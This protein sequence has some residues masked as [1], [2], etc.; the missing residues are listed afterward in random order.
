MNEKQSSSFSNGVEQTIVGVTGL[1][2]TFHDNSVALIHE[3]KLLFAASQ[4]RYSRIKHDRSFPLQALSAA[5]RYSKLRFDDVTT[6]A[7]GYPHRRM[8]SVITHRY[9]YDFP[10]LV[11]NLLIYRHI[12]LLKDFFLIVREQRKQQ[13]ESATKQID[14]NK[15]HV[16]YVDHHKAHAASAYYTSGYQECIVI[17]LDGFGSMLSGTLR[18][19]AAFIADKHTLKEVMSVPI[20]ASL[21]LFYQSVT[22]AL[23]F[24][25]G[26]GEGKTMGLA[27]YG[28]ASHT[29]HKLRPFAPHFHN[30]SWQKGRHWLSAFFSTQKQ[31]APLFYSTPLGR[32]LKQLA[33]QEKPEDIAA[34]A[35]VILEEELITFVS[36]CASQYPQSKNFALAGGVF[37]NVKVNKKIRELPIVKNVFVHPNAGDGGCALGAAY[38]ALTNQNKT[39]PFTSAALGESFTSE[40]ILSTLKQFDGITYEKKGNIALYGATQLVRGKVI[41]WFQGRSEWGARALGFRSVLADP[42][43]ARV[44]DR[45]NHVLK[46]REWF[47]PFAPSV[48]QEYAPD[49]FADC[50]E[51]PFMTMAYDVIKDKEQ[52]IPAAIHIDN[53]ARPNTVSKKN[54]PLYYDLIN[55]FYKKTG[56]PVVLNTSFNRH[57]LPIINHPKEAVEHLLWGAVDELIIG[58]FAVT[59]NYG[60]QT[61][62]QSRKQTS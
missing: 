53:T 60:E 7:V 28:N 31:Y 6:I 29:Y 22:L 23:G 37:L 24:T 51:S 12:F 40:D 58:D 45:I 55:A 13:S 17:V 11:I 9:W 52:R 38:V 21:G 61:E 34:G 35:Q 46:N 8:L 19:G 2:D 39:A 3:G 1:A 62:T 41:G 18:A 47:M 10:L 16:V 20:W 59:K 54:N 56:V 48:L 14:I 15:K 50:Q 57:G 5:L 33:A 44:R 42:R 32:Y 36:Y 43:N 49:Y 26:D 25:P 27:A 4:E 30:G